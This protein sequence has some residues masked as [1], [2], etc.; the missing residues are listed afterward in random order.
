MELAQELVNLKGLNVRVSHGWWESFRRRHPQLSLRTASPL[1]YAR[2]V[3]SDLTIIAKYFNLL[4]HTLVD[5]LLDKPS[6]ILNLDETGMPLDP[7]LPC[8]VAARGMKHPSEIGSGD[9][10]ISLY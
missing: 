6:E 5:E 3:G 9:K 1:S 10:S 7:S 2:V 8:V 4:K